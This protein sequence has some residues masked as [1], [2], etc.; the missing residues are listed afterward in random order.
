MDIHTLPTPG[1]E[2]RGYTRLQK[3]THA[4]KPDHVAFIG[5]SQEFYLTKTTKRVWRTKNQKQR[6][7]IIAERFKGAP[8]DLIQAIVT[9]TNY[10]PY[11]ISA[12]AHKHKCGKHYLHIPHRIIAEQPRRNTQEVVKSAPSL[13]GYQQKID[14]LYADMQWDPTFFGTVVNPIPAACRLIAI[15]KKLRT[16]AG[17]VLIV[18]SP[19]SFYGEMGFAHAN[20]SSSSIR[21]I[22][23]TLPEGD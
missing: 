16:L 15:N 3:I 17:K 2:P 8:E 14:Q 13:R 12:Y 5:T 6:L 18:G 10:M 23:H 9:N 22:E 11:V 7:E 1:I 21:I 20:R 4:L 19:E